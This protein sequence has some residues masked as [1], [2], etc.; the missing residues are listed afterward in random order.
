[1]PNR[2]P[3]FGF[4]VEDFPDGKL[5]VVDGTLHWLLN[6]EGGIAIGNDVAGC[7]SATLRA[8]RPTYV[9]PEWRI[10]LEF[11]TSREYCVEF[12]PDSVDPEIYGLTGTF[13][14][15]IWADEE[16]VAELNATY[17]DQL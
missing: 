15:C 2:E 6:L 10:R 16:L 13:K 17:V 12:T 14:L 7:G 9:P 5:E 8:G 11:D 3:R 4:D 1:M